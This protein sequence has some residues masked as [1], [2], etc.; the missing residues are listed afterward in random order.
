M[1]D[2]KKEKVTGK[3]AGGK[4]RAAKMTAAERKESAKKAA[5]MKK[6]LRLLACGSVWR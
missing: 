5:E 1:T 4:A 3:A 6:T 2:S